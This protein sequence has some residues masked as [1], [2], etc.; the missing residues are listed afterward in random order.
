MNE[1]K[2]G[3]LHTPKATRP[4][5]SATTPSAKHAAKQYWAIEQIAELKRTL[6]QL[7]I[8]FGTAGAWTENNEPKPRYPLADYATAR[9]LFMIAGI[10]IETLLIEL[11]RLEK[12]FQPRFATKPETDQGL[13]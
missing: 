8:H 6:D 7:E 5:G 13:P 10:S 3:D 2:S 11:C 12:N 9:R 4:S 1:P